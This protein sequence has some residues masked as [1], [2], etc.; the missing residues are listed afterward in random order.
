MMGRALSLALVL[1]GPAGALAQ[2]WVSFLEQRKQVVP[3]AEW[4]REIVARNPGVFRCRIE[5]EPPFAVTLV[6]DRAYQAMLRRDPGGL[7]R[8]DV[9]ISADSRERV[10]D[11]VFSVPSAGSFWLILA[12]RSGREVDMALACFAQGKP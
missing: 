8:E 11:R 2:P 4:N 10:F 6:A 7:K 5:S 1:L 9:L 12:N 3:Q